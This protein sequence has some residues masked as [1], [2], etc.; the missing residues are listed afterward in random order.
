MHDTEE[1]RQLVSIIR[2]AEVTIET[3]NQVKAPNELKDHMKRRA[4][5]ATRAYLDNLEHRDKVT[6]ALKPGDN[7]LRHQ[8]PVLDLENLTLK[9]K[10]RKVHGVWLAKLLGINR[11]EV[12]DPDEYQF[13]GGRDVT[14]A[15]LVDDPPK[16]RTWM[17]TVLLQVRGTKEHRTADVELV[18]EMLPTWR[19][20]GKVVS[21]NDAF[22][23]LGSRWDFEPRKGRFQE[24]GLT[25]DDLLVSAD[26]TVTTSGAFV[27]KG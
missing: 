14:E 18:E 26:G 11:A 6:P 25:A 20:V 12:T 9:Y 1:W 5:L 24:S 17:G 13:G 16:M 27:L 23:P 21:F 7:R 19:L 2:Q 10:D 8:T 22:L 4:A 15:E 3:W